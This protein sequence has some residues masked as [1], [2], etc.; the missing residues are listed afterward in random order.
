LSTSPEILE[1][2]IQHFLTCLIGSPAGVAYILTEEAN[3]RDIA[4]IQAALLHDT[5]EDT[6]TTL[7][8]IEANFGAH[9]ASIV[10][11]VTDD[12]SLPYEERKR[13]QVCFML[14]LNT[15]VCRLIQLFVCVHMVH[16]RSVSC[17]FI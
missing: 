3:V 1:C 13:L 2:P 7:E 10:A 15:C 17:I 5:V 11:E 4:I 8:E 12:K 14:V 9:V 16:Q 6:D